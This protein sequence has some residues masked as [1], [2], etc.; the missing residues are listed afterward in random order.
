[1]L[2]VCLLACVSMSLAACGPKVPTHTGY[3]T[4]AP[5]KSAKPLA[6]DENNQIQTKG[7]LDYGA[8]KRARWYT[9]E[10]IEP[11]NL[12]VDLSYEPTDD[13]GHATVALE[14]LDPHNKVISEDEDAPLDAPEPERRSDDDDDDDDDGDEVES[15]TQKNRRLEN[16]KPGVYHVHLFLVGRMDTADYKLSLTYTPVFVERETNFPTEVAMLPV[17]PI[18]PIEDDAP[19]VETKPDKKPCKGRKCPKAD[20]KPKTDKPKT[21]KPDDGPKAGAVEASVVAAT[22]N[23][24][25]GTDITINAGMNDGL[26]S[27]SSGKIKGLKNGGFTVSSCGQKSCKASVK[28][29][30]DQ[31]KGSSM[32][33]TVNPK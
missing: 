9:I 23:G 22:S 3:K 25:G 10:L 16:L 19:R 30:V 8:Y 17:L 12:V 15:S 2:R 14:V 18:V 6:F 26:A 20:P 11:A 24:S 13:A 29:T 31:V 5:W 1:M 7:K 4:K 21:D 33:V 32:E 27:G 28:A